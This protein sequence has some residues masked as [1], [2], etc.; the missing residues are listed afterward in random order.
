MTTIDWQTHKCPV[1]SVRYGVRR[2]SI[3]IE[4][5]PN[6]DLAYAAMVGA[7]CTCCKLKTRLVAEQN[8]AGR[9]R[10][11]PSA[12]S[13]DFPFAKLRPKGKRD[14]KLYVQQV[15]ARMTMPALV[16]YVVP[17]EKTMDW[18]RTVRRRGLVHAFGRPELGEGVA[19]VVPVSGSK[20]GQ[21]RFLQAM[22]VAYINH[23]GKL[24]ARIEFVETGGFTEP[25]K[26]TAYEPD[27]ID[28]VKARMCLQQPESLAQYCRAEKQ[29]PTPTVW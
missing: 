24:S 17:P 19:Y 4:P 9:P 15:L 3:V 25:N 21:Y 5:H 20:N 13:D 10:L 6:E 23:E 2:G 1:G 26:R 27:A 16:R 22:V 7:P 29:S 11:K 28:F 12:T 8:Q 18:V 14:R